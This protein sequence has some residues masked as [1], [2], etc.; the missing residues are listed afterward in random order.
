[1]SVSLYR[2]TEEVLRNI[3]YTSCFSE[4][5]NSKMDETISMNTEVKN[6]AFLESLSGTKSFCLKEH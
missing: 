5:Y 4:V 2:T 6:T 1:M 3:E